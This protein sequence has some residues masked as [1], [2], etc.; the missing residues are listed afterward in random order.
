MGPEEA[1]AAGAEKIEKEITEK[2]ERETARRRRE[3]KA[4]E[5]ERCVSVCV[6]ARLCVACVCMC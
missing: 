1:G 3:E 6:R 4:K 5:E 2:E